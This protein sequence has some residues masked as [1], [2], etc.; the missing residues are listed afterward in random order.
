MNLK[1]QLYVCTLAQTGSLS[2]A[3][4]LLFIS[5]PALSLYISNLEKYLG[6]IKYRYGEAEDQDHIGVTTGLAWTEV[7]GDILFIEAV[8]M[9]GKGKITQTGKLGEV[10]KESIETA[11]SVVRAHSKELG[12]DPE[13][14]EKTDIHVHICLRMCEPV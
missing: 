8:D 3:A 5:Q 6:V 2:K 10:M 4:Q 13:I 12:I 7:G 14:F 1:E 9:P 11:Y